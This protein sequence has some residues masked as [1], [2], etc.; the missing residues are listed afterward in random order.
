MVDRRS[1]GHARAPRLTAPQLALLRVLWER[2]EATVVEI[3]QA[4]L[5]DRPLAATTIATLLTRL[6]KRG[7]VAYRTEGRR[8]VYRAVLRQ[9]DAQQEALV[10]VT[11]GL[12]EGD[13]A[14]MVSQLLSSHEIRR[15]DLARVRALIEAKETGD[16]EEEAV[17]TLADLNVSSA[18]ALAWLLTYAIHSTILLGATV[19]LASRFADEHAWLDRL[20]KAALIG[21][22][23]TAS[24]QVGSSVTPLGGYWSISTATPVVAS[25]ATTLAPAA[26]T[27]PTLDQATGL[28]S[29]PAD[30]RGM[31]RARPQSAVTTEV[32]TW[33]R[34]VAAWPSIAVWLWLA[35]AAL[36]LARFGWRLLRVHRV[37]GA[38]PSFRDPHL[39]EIIDTLCD[40]RVRSRVR[41]TTSGICAVPLALAGG[42]IVLPERFLHQL[43]TEEQRVALAHELAHVVRR[44]P[45]GAFWQACSSDCSSSN[46]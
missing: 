45:R 25:P 26:E 19:I 35:I 30:D 17:M 16:Q 34:V 12:F 3:E 44:D 41:L 10:E 22:L 2:S 43:D 8:D 1:L 18:V 21:P 39:R 15:G 4:L 27:L 5:D 20:W 24:V 13:V 31:Q 23:I 32:G 46:R 11:K 6:E 28:S 38:G 14:E 40:A 36:G 9:S 7:I 42:R 29:P 33:Q 37:L